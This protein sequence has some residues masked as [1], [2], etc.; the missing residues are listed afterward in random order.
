MYE[1]KKVAYFTRNWNDRNSSRKTRSSRYPDA[2]M[3]LDL[4]LVIHE[5]VRKMLRDASVGMKAFL[6]DEFTV[7]LTVV[8]M[9]IW[10]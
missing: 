4:P 5:Y 8:M 10:F 9:C 7:G 1:G 3:T 6:L 2:Q